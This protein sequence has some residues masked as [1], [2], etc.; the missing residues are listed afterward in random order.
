MKSN[1]DKTTFKYIIANYK[2][3]FYRNAMS[4]L[5]TKEMFILPVD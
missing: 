5:S 2:K 3:R 1:T 4:L